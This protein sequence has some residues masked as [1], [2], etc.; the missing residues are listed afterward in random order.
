MKNID[1]KKVAEDNGLSTE[2]FK[3]HLM[4]STLVVM[5]LECEEKGSKGMI[6]ETEDGSQ[7]IAQTVENKIYTQQM[8]ER[9]H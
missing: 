2:E 5:L 8:K 9:V 3:E 4:T 7:L 6:F 1:W